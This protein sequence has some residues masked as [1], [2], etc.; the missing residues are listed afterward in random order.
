MDVDVYDEDGLPVRGQ[1]GHLVC[2][3]PAPSMTKGFL[4]DRERY[5]ETYF[6]RWPGV[7]YH[8]DWALID[9]DGFWFLH[10]RADDTIKVAGKRLG[11]GEV[12]S[13]LISHEAVAEAAA[14]GVPD[15]TKGEAVV[16]FVVLKPGRVA[17]EGL[18][19]ALKEQVALVLGKSLKPKEVRFV[20]ALP[21]TRSAKIVRAV[22][23]RVHL[24]QPAGDLSS[25]ENPDTVDAIERST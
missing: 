1:V 25:V 14:I 3:K 4:N 20:A 13:A 6:S 23:R 5:L 19:L 9:E 11:P 12:E 17:D 15:E 7:W 24:G 2:K 22:I 16:C 21:K 18:R 10:G 8:G